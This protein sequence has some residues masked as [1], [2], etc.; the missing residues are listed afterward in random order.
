MAC[1]TLKK[2]ALKSIIL[3]FFFLIILL[4]IVPVER[5]ILYGYSWS[6][7]FHKS[8]KI[9]LTLI[10]AFIVTHI[11][12]LCFSKSE[13]AAKKKRSERNQKLPHH[14]YFRYFELILLYLIVSLC[15]TQVVVMDEDR[16]PRWSSFFIAFFF[17]YVFLFVVFEKLVKPTLNK[18]D[19]IEKRRLT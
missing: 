19:Q 2:E 1:T 9:V 4:F 7:A 10:G 16:T 12:A 8:V 15:F 14:N 11:A 3:F 6:T 5:S 18:L 13:Y 17:S